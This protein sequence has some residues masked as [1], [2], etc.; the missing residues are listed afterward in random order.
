MNASIIDGLTAIAATIPSKY[1]Y[2]TVQ[3]ALFERFTI[4][5]RDHAFKHGQV[6]R[7]LEVERHRLLTTVDPDKVS[8][9]PMHM[10]VVAPRKIAFGSFDFDHTG[11]CIGQAAA[12]IRGGHG[13]F[14]CHHQHPCKG[15]GWGF[16]L[17][18]YSSV[19]IVHGHLGQKSLST[20]API[21]GTTP[22]LWNCQ[23]SKR[24]LPCMK[25]E[26][27]RS[28]QNA[29]PKSRSPSVLLQALM[30]EASEHF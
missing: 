10:A 4:R 2:D 27:S 30:A 26:K 5:A 11:T 3:S 14:Q 7:L 28:K 1:F 6:L 25:H 9:F 8:A 19:Q 13:L 16:C 20:C 29:G 24:A 17:G 18:V 23:C 21:V 22:P 15:F 12:A